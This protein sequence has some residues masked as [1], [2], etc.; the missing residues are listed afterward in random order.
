[1]RK[2]IYAML[3]VVFCNVLLHA[4]ETISAPEKAVENKPIEREKFD[5]LRNPAEDLT[6]DIVTAQKENKRI[7]LDIGGEWCG[8]CRLMDEYFIK[9]SELSKLRDDNFVWLK[10]N[11]SEENENKE[12]LSKYPPISGYPHLFVLESD[13]KFLHSQGTAILESGKSYDLQ[14][15]T[16]FLKKWSPSE[17]ISAP[18]F[19]GTRRPMI[20]L[21]EAIAIANEYAG[22]NNIS[23]SD[24]YIDSAKF[25]KDFAD[26]S[27]SYWAIDW[28]LNKLAKGG[29]IFMKIFMD[30]TVEVGYGE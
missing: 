29:Q 26:K 4:Q 13:G 24:K 30:K 10:V 11:M 14:K 27:K 7:I 18:S 3:L 17:K 6:A 5:P 9:N 8:W 19:V 1:M 16:D 21:G 25:H 2:I 15:F 22:Q 23:I 12:F 28:E 20:T